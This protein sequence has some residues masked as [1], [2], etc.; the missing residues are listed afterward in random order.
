MLK[1]FQALSKQAGGRT[2]GKPLKLIC[3]ACK[4]NLEDLNE[5]KPDL[6]FSKELQDGGGWFRKADL[7]SPLCPDRFLPP[8]RAICSCWRPIPGIGC[9][10]GAS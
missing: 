8:S 5:G 3:A 7:P 9:R 10:G 4:V 1:E 6:V 2:L